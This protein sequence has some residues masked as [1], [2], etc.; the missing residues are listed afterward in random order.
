MLSDLII[1]K[2]KKQTEKNIILLYFSLLLKITSGYKKEVATTNVTPDTIGRPASAGNGGRFAHCSHISEI[3]AGA[4]EDIKRCDV[5][6]C[7]LLRITHFISFCCGLQ[8]D[9]LCCHKRA[10]T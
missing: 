2:N 7:F 5:K 1:N 8:K 10:Q 4:V 9:F 6:N 3:I